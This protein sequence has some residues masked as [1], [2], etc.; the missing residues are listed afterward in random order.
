[1]PLLKLSDIYR[2]RYTAPE[3]AREFP[4][5]IGIQGLFLPDHTLIAYECLKQVNI[6]RLKMDKKMI[7]DYCARITKVFISF[8]REE[9]WVSFFLLLFLYIKRLP[10]YKKLRLEKKSQG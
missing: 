1:M 10:I 2:S 3:L 4:E 7:A 8:I 5:R 6:Q 9:E